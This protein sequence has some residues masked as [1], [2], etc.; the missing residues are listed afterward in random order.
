MLEPL[1]YL[2]TASDSDQASS[3]QAQGQCRQ[4]ARLTNDRWPQNQRYGYCSRVK[5]PNECPAPKRSVVGD[6]SITV[7]EPIQSGGRKAHGGQ[8]GSMVCRCTGDNDSML[9]RSLTLGRDYSRRSSILRRGS[10]AVS[11]RRYDKEAYCK[12][13]GR[14]LEG[15][16]QDVETLEAV[17]TC[18]SGTRTRLP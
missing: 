11:E 9:E 17:L 3:L 2:G 12:W 4:E 8:Y 1:A 7:G 13:A 15:Q 16:C 18:V 5:N 6:A 14:P 10:Q